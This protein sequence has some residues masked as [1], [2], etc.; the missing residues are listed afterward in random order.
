MKKRR[1]KEQ[2]VALVVT[3][4]VVAML[5][6]VG[7]ALMQSVGA[8]RA[9]SRSVANYVKARLA[10]EAGVGFASALLASNMTNDGFIVVANTN[11][12][13]FVGTNKSGS[14]F[15]YTPLF[16]TVSSVADEV[17]KIES[18]NMPTLNVTAE[19]K[20]FSLILSGVGV[21]SPPTIS[22]VYLTNTNSQTNA[23]FAFWVEDL[24]GKLD[25]SVA[26]TNTSDPAARRPAGTNPAELALWAIFTSAPSA[27]KSGSNGIV[28]N[29]LVDARPYILTPAAARLVSTN[30]TTD[31]LADLTANLRYDTNEPEVIPYGFGYKDEG[32]AKFNL[33]AYTN[34]VDSV[35]SLAGTINANLT[36]FSQRSGAMNSSAYVKGIA[37]SII[38]YMDTDNV[39]TVDNAANPSYLGIENIPWPNE[40][41]DEVQFVGVTDE[42]LLRV[43]L[44]DWIE[45]W[46]MGN[47]PTQPT[48]I[49]IDNNY[50]M[51]FIFTNSVIPFSFEVNL[52]DATFEAGSLG[53]RQFTVPELQPNEYKVVSSS[54]SPGTRVLSWQ[55][56][57]AGISADPAA[58][59]AWRLYSPTN[60]ETKNM[61]YK[62]FVGGVMIQQSKGG[63]WPRYLS[64]AS[65]MAPSPTTPNKFIFANPIGFSS[66][67]GPSSS[68]AKP[69]HS[70][71]DPR[72]QLFLSG[73]L[74]SQNYTNKYSSPGGRNW[75]SANMAQ[76]PESEVH[77]GK[78]WPDSGHANVAD[79]GG[80]PTDYTQ[81]PDTFSK[82]PITN[83]SVMY[84]NDTGS[85]SS[86]LE[87]GNIYDPFQWA[88]TAAPPDGVTGAD[89]PGVWT[90]L[91]AN[92]TSDARFGGRNTLRIGRW[93]FS[94]FTNDGMRASQ[95]LDIFA[96]GPAEPGD[97]PGNPP[98]R[99]HIT[100]RININTA[101]T[102]VLRALAAGVAHVTDPALQPDGVDFFVPAN[103][104]TRFVSGITNRRGQKP[105][106]ST[107]ELNMVATNTNASS[108]PTNA[109]FGNMKLA[110]VTEWNDRAAEE[111]FSKVYP[112]SSVSSR[113]FIVYAVGQALQPG[114][115]N[116]ISTVKGA[117]QIYIK[118]VRNAGTGLTTNCVPEI[119][120]SWSL[121]DKL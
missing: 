88:D 8:D 99:N 105:F 98:V 17:E 30:V 1:H 41:F 75:E 31:I 115:T 39:P 22:W 101:T 110:N 66:Q 65:A 50:D 15:S 29:E 11:N 107:S 73:P 35:D 42:G 47:K 63:R 112:L 21:T 23:R 83:N 14:E 26:G 71:G 77:P 80:N 102:N 44:K 24:S 76:F 85:F 120:Q 89:Q 49:A 56:P 87:L 100:G 10:A 70:G 13:L 86:I 55:L 106:F 121:Q 114:T 78:F 45:V 61:S 40:L 19:G 60:L 57:T 54:S 74:R 5:A 90:N 81:S 18:S 20:Q 6:V 97:M 46:N 68:N 48:T 28:A 34:G 92:A 108:W 113:N 9:S 51:K 32:K 119:V 84:R 118:P 2:G 58:K 4:I 69:A 43:N 59:S 117:Y 104:V 94:K 103:V 82:A 25:L 109:L 64:A 62:A 16:S 3:V 38:D 96:V 95:L 91:T 93:E 53:Q 33:N 52:K 79:L 37:A 27:A 7:V 111:W 36:N 67:T 72:A 116:V 12:Q